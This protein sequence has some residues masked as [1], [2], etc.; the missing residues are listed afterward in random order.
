MLQCGSLALP[1]HPVPFAP[2]APVLSAH[3]PLSDSPALRLAQVPSVPPVFAAVHA[4]HW[5][6]QAVLQHTPSAQKPLTQSPPTVQGAPRAA[7]PT[8]LGAVQCRLATQSVFWLQD[9]KHFKTFAQTRPPGQACGALGTQVPAP[10]HKLAGV[11]VLPWQELELH[12][13]DASHKTHAWDVPLHPAPV[14]PQVSFAEA[15]HL[16][17]L[18]F[19]ASSIAQVPLGLPVKALLQDSQTPSQAASQHTPSLRGQKPDAHGST[20]SQGDPLARS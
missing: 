5:P 6:L 8:Q 18:C 10:S 1:L 20:W 7:A 4:M 3:S 12:C 15:A 17:S 19:P 9:V 2:Q 13:V 11:R 14:A 16:P